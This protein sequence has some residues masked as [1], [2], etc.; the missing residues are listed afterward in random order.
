[1]TTDSRKTVVLSYGMGVDSTTILLRWLEEPESRDFELEDLIVLTSMTGDEFKETGE[2]V[3]EHIL[4]RLKAHGVRW[5]QVARKGLTVATD[6]IVVLSDSR[7]TETV[8][9][10]GCYKLS[11]E[12]K[13]AG[14]I[15]NTCGVRKCSL[16]SKGDVLDAWVA[17][18]LGDSPYRHVIGFNADEGRRV[19]KDQTFGKHGKREARYPLVEW[20]WDR[21][22]CEAYVTAVTGA[23]WRKS[24]C[25]FCPYA[26]RVEARE[27][28]EKEPEGGG[29]ALMLEE[30]AL[31][32]N[33]R[34]KLYKTKTAAEVAG[35]EAA[36][37]FKEELLN[38]TP[39]AVYRMERVMLEAKEKP[40]KKGAVA[41]SIKLENSQLVTREA[42]EAEVGGGVEVL[43]DTGEGYPRLEVSRVAAP[44]WVKEKRGVLKKTWDAYWAKAEAFLAE[45]N[46]A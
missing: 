24:C 35:N 12:M 46:G 38:D 10:A 29:L 34:M 39:W 40:G 44:A 11:D 17:E 21:L 23:I 25:T 32:F 22:T 9:L 5:V 13:E 15:P 6:G 26:K 41:R 30:V 31:R 27:A 42:A 18:E 2:L 19:K 4:P 36:E 28:F 16:H 3:T 43:R 14:T 1:M 37:A 7:A 8:H 33:P 20:D 45:G